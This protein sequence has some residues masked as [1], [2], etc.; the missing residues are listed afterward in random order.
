[1]GAM[2]LRSFLEL[3]GVPHP[4]PEYRGNPNVA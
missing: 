3:K 4:D 1:M 2:V